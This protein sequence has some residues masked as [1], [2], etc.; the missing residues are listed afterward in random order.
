V[1]PDGRL[2]ITSFHPSRQNTNTGR[3]TRA[4]WY[5]VFRSARDAVRTAT[6]PASEGSGVSERRVI[7]RRDRPKPSGRK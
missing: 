2:L 7:S 3:L 5:A 4:M 1:L 6:D